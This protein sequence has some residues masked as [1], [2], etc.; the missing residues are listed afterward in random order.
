LL[1]TTPS[2]KERKTAKRQDFHRANIKLAEILVFLPFIFYIFANNF[3]LNN[4][5]RTRMN[6]ATELNR[7]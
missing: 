7:N 6:T 2:T 3:T 4:H 5:C 1:P